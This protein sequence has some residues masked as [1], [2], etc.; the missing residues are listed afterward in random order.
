[1]NKWIA[2]DDKI[3]TKKD[4]FARLTQQHME[5]T[6]DSFRRQFKG[7][8]QEKVI[9]NDLNSNC[10]SFM[11]DFLSKQ[12]TSITKVPI[13]EYAAGTSGDTLRKLHEKV[14]R[15]FCVR[16]MGQELKIEGAEVDSETEKSK[17]ICDEKKIKLLQKLKAQILEELKK[18][19]AKD[20]CQVTIIIS[21]K[22][23][24]KVIPSSPSDVQNY[25]CKLYKDVARNFQR[26]MDYYRAFRIQ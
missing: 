25:L 1:M 22:L 16:F 3:R 18:L 12:A 11:F 5:K 14:C 21:I 19:A 26:R 13:L 6:L 7:H 2:D 9:V 4:S 15:E 23:I 24:I 10:Q 8:K 17:V 20:E